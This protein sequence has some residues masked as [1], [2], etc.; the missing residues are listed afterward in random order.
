MITKGKEGSCTRFDTYRENI[1]RLDLSAASRLTSLD[2][3]GDLRLR[4]DPAVAGEKFSP[5]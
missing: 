3:L 1:L 4:F 2:R 5:P